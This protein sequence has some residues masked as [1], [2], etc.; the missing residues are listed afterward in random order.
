MFKLNENR[1]GVYAV[2]LESKTKRLF[3]I[4][5]VGKSYFFVRKLPIN[6]KN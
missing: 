2:Y 1:H 5:C 4:A 6:S 3:A